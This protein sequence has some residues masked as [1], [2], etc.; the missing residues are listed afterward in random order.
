MKLLDLIDKK[1]NILTR[2]DPNR[3]Y[4][5]NI[6]SFYNIPTKLAKFFCEMAVKQKYFIKKIAI[7]CPNEDC[8]R[9]VVTI[10]NYSEIPKLVKCDQCELLERYPYEFSP[11]MKDLMEF[12]QLTDKK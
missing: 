11:T 2:I 4:V 9:V 5:E 3:I 10:N 7:I 8:N 1:A 6:R 12:Y